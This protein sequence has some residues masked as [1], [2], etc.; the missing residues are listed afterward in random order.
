MLT[1]WRNREKMKPQE[2]ITVKKWT[3]LLL[4]LVM[5]LVLSA[6]GQKTQ[7]ENDVV[8]DFDQQ[9]NIV[10]VETPPV[11][12]NNNQ[13]VLITP[14]PAPTQA[15]A[16]TEV[17][18][19]PA[20]TP[21]PAPAPT[22]TPTPAPTPTPTQRN[23]QDYKATATDAEIA[24]GKTGYVTGDGVNFRVGPGSNYKIIDSY[25]KGKQLLIL[26]TSGGWTKVRIDGVI[27]YMYSD[28][29]SQVDPTGNNADV[30]VVDVTETPAPTTAPDPTPTPGGN[31]GIVIVGP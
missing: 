23:S 5:L 13:N 29:V 2:G 27:G 28:Y 16:P 25:E 22:P 1:G 3:A 7:N 9:E 4:A 17:T 14:F 15:P 12:V 26:G 30:T 31:G 18:P 8:Y 19:V 20:P 24:N 6:C 21:T 10:V 11:D